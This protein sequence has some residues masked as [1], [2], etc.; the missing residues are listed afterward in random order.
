VTSSVLA[1][2]VILDTVLLALAVVFIV[3]LLRSHAEILRRLATLEGGE[4]APR[5]AQGPMAATGG[6]APDIV[7]ETLA[8]DAVKLRLGSGSQTTLLAFLSSGCAPCG[9]LWESLRH[10]ATAP[11]GARLLI[12]VKDPEQESASRLRELAPAGR[13]VLMSTKAWHDYSVPA[14]PH[15]VL[16]DGDSGAIAGRGTAVSWEQITSMVQQATSDSSQTATDTTASSV[17]T[18]SERAARAEEAL[19]AAGI[20]AGH[21]SLYPATDPPAVGAPT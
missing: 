8:G 2:L 20:D 3:G 15:F 12:V 7:G 11:A 10:G 13:E 14:T 4:P 19:T 9:P 18:T 5:D 17:R 16:V 6:V 21:P 1:T